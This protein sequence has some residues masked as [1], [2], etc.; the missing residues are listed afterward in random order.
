MSEVFMAYDR[1]G[2]LITLVFGIYATLLAFGYL[3]RKPKNP[4]M[5]LE[6]RRK[7]GGMMQVLG[8]LVA[9]SGVAT[10]AIGL[11]RDPVNP[12]SKRVFAEFHRANKTREAKGTNL[13]AAEVF[14][15][16]LRKID[17]SKAPPELRAAVEDYTAAL[18]EGI[19]AFKSGQ[20]SPRA[21]AQMT[22]AKLRLQSIEA[23][24]RR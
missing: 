14:V 7:F 23:R 8:P 13:P 10:L 2:G 9:L 20:K 21:D 24:L 5:M 18:A 15:S 1:W 22:D 4:E 11:S 3:P 16:D 12:A 19:A 6:W 17:L